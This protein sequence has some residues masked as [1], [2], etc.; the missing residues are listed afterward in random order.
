MLEAAHIRPVG[1]QGENRLDNGLLLRSDVHTLFDGGYLGVHSE[2]KTLLV[3]PRLRAEWG[4]G[5]EFY[6][7][8]ASG[9]PIR[10][11][12]RVVDRPHVDFL[13]WHVDTVFKT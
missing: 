6:Q 5:E 3:S 12:A 7:Q 8:A 2:K 9:E 13:T 10:M 4:N 1:R 11:P